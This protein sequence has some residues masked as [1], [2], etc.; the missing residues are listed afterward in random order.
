MTRPVALVLDNL[1]LPDNQESLDAVAELALRLPPGSQVALASRRAPALP[2]ALLR[3]QGQVVEV[4]IAELA[5]DQEEA[6]ALL[7]ATGVALSDAETAELIGRTEGWPAGLYLAALALKAGAGR[8]V[9]FTFTGDDRFMAD[10]LRSGL[11]AHLPTELLAFLTP[12]SVL[13]RMCGPLCDRV[14]AARGS[15]RVLESLED[16]NLL[17]LALDCRREW[18]RYHQLFVSCSW[19]SWNGASPSWSP[20]CTPGRP[21]GARTTGCRRWRSTSPGRGRR[22]PC[23][24]ARHRAGVPGLRRRTGRHR[25]RLVGVVRGAGV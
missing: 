8:T 1:E 25:P 11:L 14:L 17:V 15:G 23:G 3:A 24:P 4:G 19:R 18:Y 16:S 7:E 22:R 6:R 10:Y 13:E 2:V 21:A 20:S 12:T 5:A 9:G